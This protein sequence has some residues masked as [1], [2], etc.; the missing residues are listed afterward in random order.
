MEESETSAI[1]FENIGL[2]FLMFSLVE[3]GLQVAL[4]TNQ[5]LTLA[6]S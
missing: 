2:I 1:A 5:I 4:E 6:H 3:I